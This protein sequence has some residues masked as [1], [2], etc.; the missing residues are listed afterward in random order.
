MLG[1]LDQADSA[2]PA[3]EGASAGAATGSAQGR[4]EA[5]EPPP[6]EPAAE[7]PALR[8]DSAVLI[9]AAGRTDVVTDGVVAAVPPGVLAAPVRVEFTVSG[10]RP[11]TRLR[12]VARILRPDGP[13]RNAQEPVAVPG[14]GLVELSL[15]EVSAGEHDVGLTAWA[16]DGTAKPVSVRLPKVTIRCG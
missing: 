11:K 2:A 16:P 15:S 1:Q 7:R 6:A 12:A 3:S 9:D 5:A 4:P 10:A 14:S 8:I 13:S